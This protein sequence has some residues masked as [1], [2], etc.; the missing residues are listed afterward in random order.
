VWGEARAEA[1]LRMRRALAEYR[2]G[3]IHTT[4]PFHQQVMD[5]T[6]FQG[7]QFDTQFLDG[8]DGFRMSATPSRDLGKVAAIAAALAEHE[9]G[10]EAVVLGASSDPRGTHFSPWK[11]AGRGSGLRRR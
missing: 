7:G 2:I 10:Q 3:G 5:S 11:Q 1:I 8:P 4:I 6:R 9:R